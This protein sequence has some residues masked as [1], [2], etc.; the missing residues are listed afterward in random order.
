MPAKQDKQPFNATRNLPRTPP[1][2]ASEPAALGKHQPIILGTPTGPPNKENDRNAKA[3]AE[4]FLNGLS[5]LPP[6]RFGTLK[7]NLMTTVEEYINEAIKGLQKMQ[8]KTGDNAK[9]TTVIVQM[10]DINAI[11]QRFAQA[12]EAVKEQV[13]KQQQQR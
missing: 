2:K 5:P 13:N 6:P 10:R 3:S 9:K 4:N 8:S 7:R 11:K 1:Q 12:R